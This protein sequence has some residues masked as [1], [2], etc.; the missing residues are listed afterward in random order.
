MERQRLTPLGPKRG[1]KRLY[2][3]L[4]GKRKW[5]FESNVKRGLTL[6]CGC[7]Q[8]EQVARLQK[9]DLS[10][11]TIGYW[12][13]LSQ[14]R[15]VR[16]NTQ[17]LCRCR[18][19][20]T[21]WV[22]YSALSKK[23]TNSCGLC[24][25]RLKNP[26]NN[27]AGKFF[28]RLSVQNAWRRSDSSIQQ[29]EW[30]CI[31]SCPKKTKVWLSTSRILAGVKSCGC[32]KT[33]RIK[34]TQ[35]NRARHKVS[36][37]DVERAALESEKEQLMA[38]LQLH[39]PKLLQ[40]YK[41]VAVTLLADRNRAEGSLDDNEIGKRLGLTPSNVSNIR[42]RVA[43]PNY[44][45]RI[46]KR[47]VER[48]ASDQAYRLQKVISHQI[49]MSLGKNISQW[50]TSGKKQTDYYRIC[51]CDLDFL[52]KHLERQFEPGMSWE[53]YGSSPI[54]RAVWHI[55][56]IRPRASFS[57]E[58]PSHV[59]ECFNWKN[60]R[61]IWGQDNVMKSAYWNGHFWRNGRT[62]KPNRTKRFNSPLTI[63]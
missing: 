14:S 60:L 32:L 22:D 40:R 26:R 57:F 7:Y 13:V 51:G 59:L 45:K 27:L 42:C 58:N 11:S 38:S 54:G 29:I 23:R 47:A 43:D 4:C 48:W 56:H 33:D 36:L 17:W 55:D 49:R 61:P 30:L 18:C 63:L 62:H 28:G 24:G 25:T 12:V 1:R 16:G 44:Q 19:G 15:S 6:S 53:N 10:G 9:I 5:I 37:N 20:R 46:N 3:C 21:K 41:I 39:E 50:K 35:H 8:R 31:C 34:E 2:I 52:R